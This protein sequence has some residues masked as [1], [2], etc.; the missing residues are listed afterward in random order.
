MP[1]LSNGITMRDFA[2]IHIAAAIASCGQGWPGEANGDP[3]EIASRAVAV[4]N[5]L[6]RELSK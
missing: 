6:L 4:T 5:A 1:Y 2:A 3:E